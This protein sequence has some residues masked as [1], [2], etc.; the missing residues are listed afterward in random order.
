MRNK[1]AKQ[2]RKLVGCDLG[3]GT[4][5]KDQGYTDVGTK[6]FA[7]ISPDGEHSIR[8]ESVMEVRTTEDRYLYRQLKL[9][10]TGRKQDASVRK[11]LLA[12][13]AKIS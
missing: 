3:R 9:V 5:D 7:Q 13:L 6:Y 1:K 2:I 10:Y 8:E 12:D 4:L 11:S